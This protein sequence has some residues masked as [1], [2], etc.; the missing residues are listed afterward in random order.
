MSSDRYIEDQIEQ[1]RRQSELPDV[2]DDMYGTIVDLQGQLQ[3]AQ[4]WKSKLEGWVIS[5][6]VGI[7]LTVL[8]RL[9]LGI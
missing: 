1:A 4:S 7:G 5:G 3:A 2:V 6:L 8:A 9:I